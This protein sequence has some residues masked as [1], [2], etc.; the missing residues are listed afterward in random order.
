MDK[1]E[2]GVE[3]RV[4]QRVRGKEGS[5]MPVLQRDNLKGLILTSQENTAALRELQLQLIGKQW[6]GLRRL[7]GESRSLTQ[8]LRGVS[9][10]RGE[11]VKLTPLT[12]R[13]EVPRRALEKCFHR[14]RKLWEE[15]DRRC[16]DPEFSM[17]FRELRSRCAGHC[18]A[19]AELLGK[20]EA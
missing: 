17:V 10:L 11:P 2:K 7:E 3:S 13:R 20:L 12:Q 5:D 4:W 8:A 15:M 16:T 9:G 1:L 14:S 6:E 19:L 18:M